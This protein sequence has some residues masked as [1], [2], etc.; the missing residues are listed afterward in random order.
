MSKYKTTIE[1]R[2]CTNCLDS[3]SLEKPIIDI[4]ATKVWNG[5][6]QCLHECVADSVKETTLYC[7]NCGQDTSECTLDVGLYL[8]ISTEIIYDCNNFV[9]NLRDVPTLIYIGCDVYV[10]C[11]AVRHIPASIKDGVS[12]YV[13]YCRTIKGIWREMDDLQNKSKSYQ[14]KLPEMKIALLFYVKTVSR[15]R[16]T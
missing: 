15:N 16:E 10:L 7:Q 14:T 13:A 8:C 5:G 3:T 4:S 12:H 1:Y 9:S 2:Y 11:G 6:M